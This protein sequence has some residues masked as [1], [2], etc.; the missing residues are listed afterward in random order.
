MINLSIWASGGGSNCQKIIEYFDGHPI[1][2]I[3][4]I[5]TN[6]PQAGVY[7]IADAWKIPIECVSKSQIKDPNYTL[8]LLEQ[9]KVDAIILAGFLA[10]IPQYL[11]SQFQD[12]IINIHPALLPSFGGKGMYGHHIHE[13][14]SRSGVSDHGLTIHQVNAKYDEGKIIFQ[15]AIPIQP[16]TDP[17]VLSSEILKLEH[18]YYPRIIEKYFLNLPF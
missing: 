18:Y 6:N 11:I 4:L 8:N 12:K 7:R 16:Y 5:V 3:S 9:Y 13:A 10:L 15:H 2:S 17:A 1:I 14:V